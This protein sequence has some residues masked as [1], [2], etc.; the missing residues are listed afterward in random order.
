M[1]NKSIFDLCQKIPRGKVTTYKE[2][3]IALN[4]KSYRAIGRILKNN[5]TPEMIPCY[6]V[7]K[8]NGVLGGYCGNDKSNIQIKIN[9]LQ[10]DG[11]EIIGN[12]IDLKKYL[13]R[14]N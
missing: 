8:S 10:K 4:S 7:I 12:K 5:K 6:K 2:I 1:K 9:K 3:A 13:H 14:F 11:I